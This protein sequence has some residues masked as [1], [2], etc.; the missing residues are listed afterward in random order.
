MPCKVGLLLA[1]LCLGHVFCNSG[2]YDGSQELS[3]TTE[4]SYDNGEG[5]AYGFIE[6]ELLGIKAEIC[7]K[8]SFQFHLD[9]QKM[10]KGEAALKED[11]STFK[12]KT[13]EKQKCSRLCNFGWLIWDKLKEESHHLDM[14]VDH[15]TYIK[16]HIE[17]VEDYESQ[18]GYLEAEQLGDMK[19]ILAIKDSTR[20]CLDSA[21]TLI[22]VRRLRI[23]NFFQEASVFF[24][25][26]YM[27]KLQHYRKLIDLD[28]Y[29]IKN[30]LSISTRCDGP[31]SCNS[32][33]LLI[34]EHVE[35][36]CKRY[37]KFQRLQ[38][39]MFALRSTLNLGHIT[40]ADLPN[41][42][43]HYR[44][45]LSKLKTKLPHDESE[46]NEIPI[47]NEYVLVDSKELDVMD[48]GNFNP[49]AFRSEWMLFK[50]LA[51]KH[52]PA[53]SRK[54]SECLELLGI[55]RPEPTS[56]EPVSQDDDLFS[57]LQ[58]DELNSMLESLTSFEMEDEYDL[59]YPEPE[60][61][62][63]PSLRRVVFMEAEEPK[64]PEKQEKKEILFMF[65]GMSALETASC[66]F[67]SI[68]FNA[69]G[70]C[71]EGDIIPTSVNPS[72]RCTALP[73][74]KERKDLV[75]KASVPVFPFVSR[76]SYAELILNL[77]GIRHLRQIITDQFLQALRKGSNTIVLGTMGCATCQVSLE[78]VAR[79]LLEVAE[80]M[81]GR[82]LTTICITDPYLNKCIHDLNNIPDPTKDH[83]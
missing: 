2:S 28:E 66:L 6:R 79:L 25:E 71:H 47:V 73:I 34:T 27:K 54:F 24:T 9:T 60:E 76:R 58:D 20:L 55:D 77:K 36:Y 52:F 11:F 8:W 45:E 81:G 37:E 78:Q 72:L 49:E 4:E 61:N 56:P 38:A 82:G 18:L 30:Y 53:E 51:P 35:R 12:A 62:D 41:N 68:V 23:D 59:G 69:S 42:I 57:D 32:I 3:S 83:D 75:D 80:M 5:G 26:I 43:S 48:D 44:S 70:C 15:S 7:E 64:A 65:P 74:L 39:V 67:K 63:P 10:A 22:K 16:K 19:G 1:L 50:N 31:H 17:Q 46:A 13:G 40:I 29:E 14:L 33:L 21:M